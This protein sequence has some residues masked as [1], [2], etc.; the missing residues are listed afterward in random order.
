VDEM[1]EVGLGKKRLQKK[2]MLNI[3]QATYTPQ[4]Y[5]IDTVLLGTSNIDMQIQKQSNT[6]FDYCLQT[7]MAFKRIGSDLQMITRDGHSVSIAILGLFASDEKYIKQIA[8]CFQ[9][10]PVSIITNNEYI[11]AETYK[12]LNPQRG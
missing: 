7:A 10:I 3:L 2:T 4:K 12:L 6:S 1:S 11:R 5:Q 8:E 9:N